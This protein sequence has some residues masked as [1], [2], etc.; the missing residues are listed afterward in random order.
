M[1]D[2]SDSGLVP[3]L[4][5]E[6]RGSTGEWAV[7]T[8]PG[9]N[10]MQPRVYQEPPAPD[11]PARPEPQTPRAAGSSGASPGSSLPS[12]IPFPEAPPRPPAAESS[13]QLEDRLNKLEDV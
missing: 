5:A 3:V 10:P 13:K 6:C 11:D 12:A 9:D 1:T 8:A 2:W 7:S 4:A